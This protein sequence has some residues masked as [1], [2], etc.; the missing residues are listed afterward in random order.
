MID[1]SFHV[2]HPNPQYAYIA[3]TYGQAKR[4][5]W[6][7][8]KNFTKHYP[9][10]EVNEA[11]LRIDLVRPD[12]EDRIRY[13]LLGG[14]NSA[15]IRGI[16]LD[17]VILDEYADM[18]PIV[19]SQVVRP[20]L[21]DR[22]GW[23]IFIGTPKGMNHFEE[24]FRYATESDKPDWFSCLLKASETGIIPKEELEDARAVMTQ[25]EYDQEYECSFAS[26]LV[27]SIFG[28]E[29]ELAEKQGRIKD[30]AY[31]K[32]SRVDTYWDLGISDSTTIWFIQR[33]GNKFRVID[34]Y[35][36][37]GEDLTHYVGILGDRGYLYADHHFPHDV[38]ARS[39]ES[40][41]TRQEV[42]ESLLG[43]PIRVIEK[44]PVSDQIEAARNIL[45]RCEFDRIK[46]S[47]GLNSMRNFKRVWDSKKRVF[48]QP[49]HNWACLS[50]KT[51]IR[52]LNGWKKIE[53]LV[54]KDF[55]V[56]SYSESERRLIPVKAERC[57]KS[58]T[59][60]ELVRV[61]LDH[62]GYIDCT[63]D[64]RFMTRNGKWVQA[65]D[66]EP[67][68]SLMPFYER[69][70]RGYIKIHLNDGSIA[71]E[72]RFVFNRFNGAPEQGK[73]IHHINKNKYDNDPRNLEMISI[74][75]HISIHA[76]EPERLAKLNKNKPK[77]ISEKRK[78]EIGRKTVLFHKASEREK[79]CVGC[80]N[81][82]IGNY[83]RLYCC[84][85]CSLLKREA[86]RK[87]RI[88]GREFRKKHHD[89]CLALKHNHKVIS[90]QR[91][92]E[93]TDVYDISV[94]ETNNFVAEG[95][96][97]HNSHGAS[98]FMCFAIASGREKPDISSFPKKAI[99]EYDIFAM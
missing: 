32:I 97:V 70:D 5:A 40:G 60:D 58:K 50:G 51:K 20:A 11:E 42:I 6:D 73:H 44:H 52:T 13:L 68:T 27:G 57:W 24:V 17:G 4:V 91:F 94:P 62:G 37:A 59:V 36:N 83:K 12:R 2:E 86:G 22:K 18:D 14:E 28:K 64:H 10:R 16:Y 31:D 92:K 21:S 93:T 66:L 49:L 78:K 29:M 67:N 25:E 33:I 34:Y 55:Y 48:G 71:D 7:Y 45:S 26:A 63:P 41:R 9:F 72:H 80:E 99:T 19:W 47:G 76:S 77:T 75:Q 85:Y 3:P 96:I 74:E 82:F 87:V 46:C 15:G 88:K 69:I 90:V 56:W 53:D 35:E 39:L 8:L 1:Q 23:A 79:Q 95:V 38:K 54:G 61:Q 89:D 81:K 65:K 84:D 98:A 30:I 43:K